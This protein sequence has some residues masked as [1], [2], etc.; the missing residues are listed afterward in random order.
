MGIFARWAIPPPAR[1]RLDATSPS[2]A[3][4]WLWLMSLLTTRGTSSGLDWS[5]SE[6]ILIGLPRT[7]PAALISSTASMIPL[8]VEVPKAASDAVMEPYCRTGMYDPEPGT[9]SEA[10]APSGAL[11][12]GGAPAPSLAPVAGGAPPP[13]GSPSFE[14][15]DVEEGWHACRTSNVATRS[16]GRATRRDAAVART[17]SGR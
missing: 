2:S 6:K 11:V 3:T 1:E 9:P 15:A 4:M 13:F 8:W 16:S 17:R 14:G 5:S 12:A 10:G 7:P